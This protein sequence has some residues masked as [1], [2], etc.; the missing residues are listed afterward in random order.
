MAEIIK[1]GRDGNQPF[2]IKA[3]GDTQEWDR[4]LNLEQKI[5]KMS[6]NKENKL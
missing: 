4:F 5:R 6:D 3:S 2:E 1:L